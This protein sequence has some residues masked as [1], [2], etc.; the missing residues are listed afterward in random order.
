MPDEPMHYEP[1]TYLYRVMFSDGCVRDVTAHQ[2]DS[3]MRSWLLEQHYRGKT[4]E[5]GGIAGVVRL[6]EQQQ[7]EV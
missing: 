3:N 2:D 7:L 5:H 4:P 1:P 6:H